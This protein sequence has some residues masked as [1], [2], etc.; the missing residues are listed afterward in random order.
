MLHLFMKGTYVLLMSLESDTS[1]QI[2]KQGFRDFEKGGYVYIGS[3][4]QSLESRI[5][6]HLRSEKKDY[7]HI[8]Y[9]LRYACIKKV[10]IKEG[11]IREECD[12]ALSFSRC[13]PSISGFG[14]SDCS[15]ESHLYTG[16]IESLELMVRKLHFTAF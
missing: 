16:E 14:C 10:F 11:E 15:C 3:A 13:F 9:F 1:I 2:G 4:L 12:V 5:G 8:D 6:R 7:W